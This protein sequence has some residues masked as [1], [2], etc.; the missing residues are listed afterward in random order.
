VEAIVRQTWKV[1]GLD[2]SEVHPHWLI[3]ES[4]GEPI[5]VCQVLLGKP[6]GRV[7]FLC[8]RDDVPDMTRGRAMKA[9]YRTATETIRK[10][11]GTIASGMVAFSNKPVKKWLKKRGAHVF[12]SGNI[13]MWGTQ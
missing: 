13:L 11:G 12:D 8:V 6:V 5:G 4:D 9:L 2:F 10:Y 7:E 1:E 3:A